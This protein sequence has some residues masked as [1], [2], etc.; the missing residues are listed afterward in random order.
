M[1][2]YLLNLHSFNKVS[3]WFLHILYKANKPTTR[4]M[5]KTKQSKTKTTS[6]QGRSCKL[7]FRCVFWKEAPDFI[8][9]H[10]SW[11][12]LFFKTKSSD[13]GPYLSGKGTFYHT[14]GHVKEEELQVLQVV[15]WSPNS[16]CGRHTQTHTLTMMISVIRIIRHKNWEISYKVKIFNSFWLII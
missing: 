9:F 5:K 16:Q 2:M 8:C 12:L 13:E 3:N 11:N 10:F 7:L 14:R 6:F 15:F 1:T 4:K